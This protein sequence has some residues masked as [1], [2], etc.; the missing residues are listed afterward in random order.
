MAVNI[1]LRKVPT[2]FTEYSLSTNGAGTIRYDMQKKKMN[3]LYCI[4]YTLINP[5]WTRDPNV[6]AK[7]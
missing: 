6:R 5:K 7:V 3:P 1:F 2:K 4:P